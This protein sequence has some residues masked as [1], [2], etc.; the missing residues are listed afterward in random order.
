IGALKQA[1]SRLAAGDLRHRIAS[2]AHDEI[3]ELGEAFDSMAIQLEEQHDAVRV[4]E[5]RLAALVENA[6][7]GILVIGAG[8][9]IL[10]ATPSFRDYV[11]SDGMA[12]TQL[13]ELVHHDDLERVGAAWIRAVH[14]TDGSTLEIEARLKHRDGTWRHVWAKLTN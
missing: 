13:T 3:A 9:E 10:F 1:T 6:N 11:E 8:G 12:A 14:G 2:G 4:R 5:R 7:D